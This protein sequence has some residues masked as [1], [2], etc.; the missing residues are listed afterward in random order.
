MGKGICRMRDNEQH[1]GKNFPRKLPGFISRMLYATSREMN[2]SVLF[3][4][5]HCGKQIATFSHMSKKLKTF[6]IFKFILQLVTTDMFQYGIALFGIS[7]QNYRGLTLNLRGIVHV[8]Y[9]ALATQMT[10]FLSFIMP[11]CCK[12]RH[13]QVPFNSRFHSLFL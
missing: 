11:T 4:N 12:T 10:H 9:L 13:V 5:C 2:T 8:R 3:P 7:Q 6:Q 1:T